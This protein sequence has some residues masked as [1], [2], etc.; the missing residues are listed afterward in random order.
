MSDL[1]AMLE[2]AFSASQ[3]VQFIVRDLR[4]FASADDR[5]TAV[6]VN[7]ILESC[8]NIASAEIRHRARLV[9]DCQPVAPVLGSEAKPTMQNAQRDLVKPL[10][11]ALGENIS[12]AQEVEPVGLHKGQS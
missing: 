5:R 4:A 3:R 6:N 11:P 2:E 1:K 9:K 12:A 10:I 8:C 7:A